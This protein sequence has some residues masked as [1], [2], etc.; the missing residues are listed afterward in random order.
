MWAMGKYT[1][2]NQ[3]TRNSKYALKVTRL[4]KAPVMSA[5]VIWANIIWYATNT[6]SGIVGEP[7]NGVVGSIFRKNARLKL[8][9]IPPISGFVA[10]P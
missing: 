4:A 6:T 5:G 1:S 9:T 8:P 2:S 7:G 3:A 10:L